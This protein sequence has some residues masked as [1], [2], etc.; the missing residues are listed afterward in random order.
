M[1]HICQNR[2]TVIPPRKIPMMLSML[3]PW[4]H[5]FYFNRQ[6]IIGRGGIQR[7]GEGFGISM[8]DIVF[9]IIEEQKK[10]S[11]FNKNSFAHLW[12]DLAVDQTFS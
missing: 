1:N 9:I 8:R 10:L 3:N 2:V 4:V 6:D 11:E 7:I 12:T 5:F